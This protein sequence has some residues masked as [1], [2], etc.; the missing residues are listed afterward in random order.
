MAVETL[1]LLGPVEGKMTLNGFNATQLVAEVE[2]KTMNM[3]DL[4]KRIVVTNLPQT[5]FPDWKPLQKLQEDSSSLCNQLTQ[6]YE[7]FSSK[8]L[9][10]DY[11]EEF[12]TVQFL[13]NINYAKHFKHRNS[14]YLLVNEKESCFTH[15]MKLKTG[16]EHQDLQNTG[17]ISQIEV[18]SGQGELFL[19]A[20]IEKTSSNCQEEDFDVVWKFIDEDLYVSSLSCIVIIT[21][22]AKC[23]LWTLWTPKNCCKALYSL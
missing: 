9:K 20:R 15:L 1:E 2:E 12:Q 16:F 13:E 7:Q 11:F 21:I 3:T 18:I 4:Q 23:R 8:F 10:F 22:H 19:V 6:I 17:V 14:D 5:T